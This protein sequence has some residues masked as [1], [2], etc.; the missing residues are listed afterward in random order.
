M[1]KPTL[2]S[3]APCPSQRKDWHGSWA[4]LTLAAEPMIAAHLPEESSPDWQ[5]WSQPQTSGRSHLRWCLGAQLCSQLSYLECWAHVWFDY[6]HPNS[7]NHPSPVESWSQF[8]QIWSCCAS[9]QSGTVVLP[10]GSARPDWAEK[11]CA[12]LELSRHLEVV[13]LG[14]GWHGGSL[15]HCCTYLSSPHRGL[16]SWLAWATME[17]CDSP[18][19]RRKE[20]LQHDQVHLFDTLDDRLQHTNSGDDPLSGVEHLSPLPQCL[21]PCPAI[22]ATQQ[23]FVDL[24]NE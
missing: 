3:C 11:W 12:V 14:H 6:I 9:W 8:Q 23:A 20:H 4:R 24:M 2:S 16:E 18:L 15:Q 22:V 21:K 5:F 13:P 7:P 1:S 17:W 10:P 19:R